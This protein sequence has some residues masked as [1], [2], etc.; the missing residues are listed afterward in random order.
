MEVAE[1]EGPGGDQERMRRRR[2]V[3]TVPW[4]TLTDANSPE[5]SE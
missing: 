2:A 1:A 4:E 5:D 3:V